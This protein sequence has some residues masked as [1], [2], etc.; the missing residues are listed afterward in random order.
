MQAV[1]SAVLSKMLSLNKEKDDSTSVQTKSS[2]KSRLS[3]STKSSTSGSSPHS[4]ETL[5]TVK[6]K[7][8]C[9]HAEILKFSDK[10]KEQE[11]ILNK[12]KLQQQ[13]SK[14]RA[15]ESVYEEAFKDQNLL[16]R[17]DMD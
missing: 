2:H 3:H 6:A 7:M 8:C 14:T 15:T 9:A 16:E 1:Q 10:I 5:I 17:D 12:P 11:N 4:K 13:L